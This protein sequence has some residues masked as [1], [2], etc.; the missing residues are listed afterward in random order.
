VLQDDY[1]TNG[2]IAGF[3]PPNN[4][5]ADNIYVNGVRLPYLDY[6]RNPQDL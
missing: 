5:Q 2:A 4:I 1:N 6:P 3:A